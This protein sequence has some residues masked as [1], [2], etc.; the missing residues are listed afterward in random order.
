MQEVDG[1]T[2]SNPYVSDVSYSAAEVG[3]TEAAV[4]LDARSRPLALGDDASLV[5]S[6]GVSYTHSLARDDY[7]VQIREQEVDG[8]TQRETVER[9]EL[10]QVGLNLGAQLGVGESLTLGAGL[11]L[12]HDPAEGVA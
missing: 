10:R 4:G 6:G 2:M 3:E 8:F 12:T 5:L 9:P 11:A 7:E 1:F